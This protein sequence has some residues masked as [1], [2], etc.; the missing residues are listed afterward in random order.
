MAP[1]KLP[2]IRPSPT[3]MAKFAPAIRVAHDLGALRS[4]TSNS[5]S[6]AVTGV[7]SS[8][9]ASAVKRACAAG[10]GHARRSGGGESARVAGRMILDLE[11]QEHHALF[12]DGHEG[13]S[14]GVLRL[15]HDL[16]G[17]E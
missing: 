6:I 1:C 10:Q 13:R 11:G 2:T 5:P 4:A 14:L 9:A 8:C 7:R 15:T 3:P 16:V 17:H 12:V